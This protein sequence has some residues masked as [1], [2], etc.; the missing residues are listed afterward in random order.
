MAQERDLLAV[1]LLMIQTST[2]LESRDVNQPLEVADEFRADEELVCAVEFLL[3]NFL[4][5]AGRAG[6]QIAHIGQLAEHEIVQCSE[7]LVER[8]GIAAHGVVRTSPQIIQLVAFQPP[9]LYAACQQ[10]NIS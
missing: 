2:L 10:R 5:R 7:Q 9:V 4:E 1:E 3:E 6:N 8:G